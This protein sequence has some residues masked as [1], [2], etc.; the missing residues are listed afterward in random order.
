ME[1][2]T[3]RFKEEVLK[4]MDD[5]IVGHNFNSRTEFIREAVRD[6]LRVLDRD[7][8]MGEFLQH[9]GKSKNKTSDDDNKKTKELLSKELLQEFDKRFS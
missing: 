8:L 1:V 2:I 5:S 6:K 7:E 3:V 9:K 4:E